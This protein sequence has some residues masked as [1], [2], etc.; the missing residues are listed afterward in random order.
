VR[1]SEINV[2]YYPDMLAAEATLKKAILLFDEL[3][4]M[5]RPS[6]SFR[7]GQGGLIGAPSPLRQFEGLF[8]EEG[9]PLYVHPAPGG[10]IADE[11]YEQIKA[12]VN[13]LEFLKR[14]QNGLKISPAFRGFHIPTGNYGAAGD[15]DSVA[16]KLIEIDLVTTLKTYESPIALF[17]DSTIRPFDVSNPVACAKFLIF[18]A[19]KCSSKLNFALSRSTKEG[20]FPLADANPYGDLLGAKY[21]RAMSKLEPAKNKIQV[22]DL[23][24]AIFDALVPSEHLEKLTI[25]D[26]IRYRKASEKAREA[27]LEHLSVLQA[28]QASIGPDGDYAGE[29]DKVV[30]TE[31]LPAARTFRNK[32]QTIGESLFGALAKGA[33][34]YLGSSAAL[35]L[36]ADLSWENLIKLA[37]P[38]GAYVAKAT[39]DA[40]LADNAARRECSIS[41]ILS[42]DE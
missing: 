15:Q 12:D 19:V 9:V 17:E 13:D 27:F 32:L 36:F 41:Y 39:I 37:A 14:F 29:I 7:S 16:E 25:E 4:F 1:D 33:V 26:V 35:S 5:D 21:A 30:T 3:H 24:F 23:T 31:V 28:K 34:G 20:F 8:R 38:V 11:L 10:P 18:D 42:L 22:T 40:I 2:L 6:F